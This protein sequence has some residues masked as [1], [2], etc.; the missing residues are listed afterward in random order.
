MVTK[1]VI[2]G[3]N[4]RTERFARDPRHGAAVRRLDGERYLVL[5]TGEI[6]EYGHTAHR[7]DGA[8]YARL[9]RS[10]AE[11]R[12]ICACNYRDAAHTLW[13]TLTYAECMTDPDQLYEDFRRYWQRQRRWF[14]R[15]GIW[16]PEYLLAVEPQ[17]RGAW[18]VHALYFFEQRDVYLP[19]DE[20]ERLWGK[21]FVSVDRPIAQGGKE[22]DNIGA[23]LSAYLADMDGCK[24]GRLHLYPPRMRFWRCSRGCARPQ[25]IW[26]EDDDEEGI[27]K[28]LGGH[29]RA[30]YERTAT[31]STADGW[32]QTITYAYYKLGS[33]DSQ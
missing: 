16:P 8:A 24:G 17:E 21:G 11:M 23:Y 28:A 3:D 12:D 30:F 33:G 2:A 4:G 15:H 9:R 32:R 22:I 1:I 29:P 20:L 7:A 5:S 27:R 25:I 14:Q 6:K 13:I 26:V 10:M 19:H 18:H 31:I